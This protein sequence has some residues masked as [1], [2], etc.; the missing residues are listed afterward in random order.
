M[1]FVAEYVAPLRSIVRDTLIPGRV[2][3]FDSFAEAKEWAK[4]ANRTPC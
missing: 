4:V 3:W 2:F 1:R